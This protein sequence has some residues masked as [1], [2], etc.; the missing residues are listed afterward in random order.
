MKCLVIYNCATRALVQNLQLLYPNWD[1]RGVSRDIAIDWI[2][3]GEKEA[4]T[5]FAETC[6]Y[7]IGFAPETV[8]GL[9]LK[10]DTHICT[11]PT[12]LF[13]G[14]HPD[15]IQLFGGPPS[16]LGKEGVIYSRLLAV[17]FLRGLNEK[18]AA[19]LFTENIFKEIGYLDAFQLEKSRLLQ[20]FK[21][22]NLD[23]SDDFNRW[24]QN[25]DDAFVFVPNH[26]RKHIYADIIWKLTQ[27]F[28]DRF[29]SPD[30]N[31][32][33]LLEKCTCIFPK[34]VTWPIYPALANAL[35]LQGSLIW[36]TSLTDGHQHL[37]LEDF[38]KR[39]YT[40]MA[41]FEKLTTKQ[42]P[43]FEIVKTILD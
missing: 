21:A 2:R 32:Q 25:V 11:I 14:F 22:E 3:S 24:T 41:Q 31:H 40:H 42:I 19:A 37:S 4:F 28:N 18:Q 5:H 23:M 27:T 30:I 12:F 35:N 8:T 10:T 13:R 26:G 7:M 20:A 1:V 6:D 34:P 16:P 39:S 17:A 33:D 38:I 15:V 9:S 36:K 43:G 29:P